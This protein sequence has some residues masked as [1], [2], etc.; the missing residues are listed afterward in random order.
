[1][2]VKCHVLPGYETRFEDAE[3]FLLKPFLYDVK[4]CLHSDHCVV[5]KCSNFVY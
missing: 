3:A 1:M 4:A 2:L 5:L